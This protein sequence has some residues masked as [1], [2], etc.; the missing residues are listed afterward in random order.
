MGKSGSLDSRAL[1]HATSLDNADGDLTARSASLG[2]NSSP[3]PAPAAHG[4]A[5][6]QSI[7]DEDS[8][9]QAKHVQSAKA[10]DLPSANGIRCSIHLLGRFN[11]W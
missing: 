2:S 9:A 3:R 11:V 8:Q 7:T 1:G 4:E 5:E 10:A 6:L